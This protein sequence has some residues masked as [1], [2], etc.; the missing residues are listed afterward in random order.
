MSGGQTRLKLEGEKE[1]EGSGH[2]RQTWSDVSRYSHH[3]S[4]NGFQ[5]SHTPCLVHNSCTALQGTTH[6]KDKLFPWMKS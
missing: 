3:P 1:L 2:Q 5:H 6:L 4:L